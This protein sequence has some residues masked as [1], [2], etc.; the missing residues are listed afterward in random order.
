MCALLELPDVV[1]LAKGFRA[2]AGAIFFPEA[3]SYPWRGGR[4]LHGNNP[5]AV[6]AFGFWQFDPQNT[7][8]KNT[9]ITI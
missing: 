2:A 4:Q 6:E 9:I 8:I 7:E 5:T 3:D 1:R